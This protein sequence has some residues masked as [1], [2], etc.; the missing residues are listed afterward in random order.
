VVLDVA[1]AAEPSDVEGLVV[2][3]VVP[4]CD[5]IAAY[6]AR[7]TIWE[8]SAGC[9]S[10]EDSPPVLG[11]VGVALSAVGFDPLG[12]ALVEGEPVC[13]AVSGCSEVTA[14]PRAESPNCLGGL[15]LSAA[16]LAVSHDSILPP[17]P[18]KADVSPLS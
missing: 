18:V 10:C 4:V 9:E 2:V 17:L 15:E 8:G 16:V 1:G 6:L 13:D 3:V 11:V 7:L 12:V 5:R 14:P